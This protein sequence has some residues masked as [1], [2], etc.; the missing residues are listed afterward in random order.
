MKNT[1]KGSARLKQTDEECGLM[2]DMNPIEDTYGGNQTL[3]HFPPLV[4]VSEL[5]GTD[6]VTEE[7]R[8][9][10]SRARLKKSTG[11]M[12]MASA[13]CNVS[14]RLFVWQIRPE[15]WTCM[16][17]FGDWKDSRMVHQ[18]TPKVYCALKQLRPLPRTCC[19]LP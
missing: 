10:A 5:V 15:I 2:R 7:T 13:A 19:A 18:N 3:F 14:K 4:P 11:S 17:I 16:L 9:L 6:Q 8:W 1:E 12:C